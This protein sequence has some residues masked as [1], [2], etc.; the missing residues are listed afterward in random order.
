MRMIED[1]LHTPE[2]EEFKRSRLEFERNCRRLE[3]QV[4]TWVTAV[5]AMFA[6]GYALWLCGLIG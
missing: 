4:V 3:D 5:A 2:A 6:G 1:R